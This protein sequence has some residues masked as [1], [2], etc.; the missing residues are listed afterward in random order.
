MGVGKD[1][2]T[3]ACG[4]EAKEAVFVSDP[5]R[6][7]LRAASR[8]GAGAAARARPAESSAQRQGGSPGPGA[9]L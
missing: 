9:S 7:A 4:L 8:G 2:A 5:R 1:R 6:S 3:E